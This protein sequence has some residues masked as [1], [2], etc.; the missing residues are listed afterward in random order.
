MAERFRIRHVEWARQLSP[1]DPGGH[2]RTAAL[3]LAH[4]VQGTYEQ[5]V[6]WTL[7]SHAAHPRAET[8]LLFGAASAAALGWHDQARRLADTVRAGHP[9]LRVER[10]V[11]FAPFREE[12]RRVRWGEQLLAAG[13]PG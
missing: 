3:A 1:F 7:R 5:S 9:H 12:A 2:H 10:V 4:Y 13:V 8:F 11:H 6:E